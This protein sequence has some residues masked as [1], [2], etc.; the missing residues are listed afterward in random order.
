MRFREVFRYELEHRFR[1]ASTW[2]QALV[3][4]LLAGWMFLATAD[5]GVEA[6]IDAPERIAGVSVLASLFGLLVTAALFGDAALRDVEVEMDPLLYTSPVGKA[7][8]LGGRFLGALAVNAL[9]SIAIPLGILTAT[10]IAAG[11]EPTGP[12]R[13]AAHLQPYFLFLLPNLVVVGAI[14]FTI[15]ALSRQVVPVY[16]GALGLFV[17][18]LVAANY[19]VGIGSP[20]AAALADPLGVAT[21]QRVT[22]YWP[23]AERNVRLIGLP[24]TLAWNRALWL[25]LATAVLA[26]LHRAF[27][28]AH[29][30]GG[31]RRRKGSRTVAAPGPERTRAVEVPRVAG[32]FGSRT[33]LRQTLAIAGNSLAEVASSRWF[34]VVLLACVGL[35]LLWSWN[36]GETVFDTSTW[37]VTLLVTEVGLSQRSAPLFVVLIVLHAGELVWKDREVGVAEIAD[38][39]PARAGVALLGRLLA[40]CALIVAFQAA[41][42]VGG[43][44]VQALQGY[45]EFEI[46]LY[47]RVVFGLKLAD[48]LLLGAL[49]T[50]IHVVVDHKYLGHLCVVLAVVAIFAAGPLL[51]VRHHLLLYGT[52]PGWTYSDINGFGP[53]VG[54]FV[55]FKLY[56]AAWAVLLAVL[57]VLFWARG[58]EAGVRHRLRRARSRFAGPVAR[59]AGVAVVLVL[60]LGGFVFYNTN[61]RN[62]YLAGDELGAPQARYEQRYGRHRRV[63]QPTIEAA[64]LRVE[65]FPDEPAVDLRGAYRLVNRTGAAIDRV[66]VC[67]APDVEARSLSLD[68]GA[69]T[70]LVD[71]EVGYR[72]YALEQALEPGGSTELSFELAF[73][74][75]GFPNDGIQTDVAANGTRFDRKRLPFVG[76]QPLFELSDDE[77]R[78]RFDLEPRPPMPSAG[79]AAALER[80]EVGGRWGPTDADLVEVDAI[81][82]T[83]AD[84]VA[85]TPGVLRRSWTENGRSYFHYETEGPA[86]FGATILSARYAVLEDRWIPSKG[87]AQA[88][89]LRVFHHPAHDDNLDRMVRGMKASLDYYTEQFGPYPYSDLRIAEVPRYGGYGSAHPHTI[90]FTEDVFFSRVR[91]GEVDQPFYGTAHEVAHTWWGGML[92]GAPVRG[93]AFLSESLANYSAM[94]VTEKTYGPEAGRRVYGFQRERYLRA[95]AAKSREVPV[96]EVEDQPYIA[97][98]KGA[99]ALY[100]LRAHIG[101]EAVNAALRRYFEKHR[102]AGPPYPTSLGLYA[103]LRAAAPESLHGLLTDLFETITL[104]DVRVERAV[105]ETTGAGEHRVTLDVAARKVRADREGRE[106]EVPMDELVE[107]G[108]FAPGDDEGLGVPLYLERHRIRSGAQ[109]ITVTVSGEP[110]SAGV[111]PRHLLI[112]PETG[113]N[114]EVVEAGG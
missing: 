7:E 60:G 64:R 39:A 75:R 91:D 69:E 2:V 72:I 46:G 89:P 45:H 85:I 24:A 67:L 81:L 50:T 79:D 4:F 26:L 68:R 29:A 9:S 44:L 37:P 35:P 58:R 101:E 52:D 103:E 94:M 59:T 65:I 71:E 30:D 41:S 6:R 49:A 53:F 66:H 92:R 97:Y 34:A 43:L 107:V 87:S 56:W 33:A 78:V 99:I 54:P 109:T 42:M 10:G 84:Q 106:T 20:I 48:Y 93:A 17:G 15:G 113:D 47:L 1:S 102:D 5:G 19:A 82:G 74:P 36:V 108:V 23:E 31:G 111:D 22:R 80:R 110:G 77:A 51:G 32:S 40:L 16:L 62:E 21:L 96:L 90:L 114:V 11:S 12:F 14:L 8:Y 105:V 70:E 13:A 98:R 55:W 112:D 100:I 104:W 61:V 86:S 28:F 88:V 83:S 76:Y 27:R 3:L 57:A 63:A 38:A 25:A 18:S 73:R 95:R